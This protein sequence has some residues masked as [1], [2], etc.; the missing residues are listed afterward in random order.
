[1]TRE[2]HVEVVESMCLSSV[3]S[4]LEE[5]VKQSGIYAR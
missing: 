4:E 5:G 2:H 1:M 3:M